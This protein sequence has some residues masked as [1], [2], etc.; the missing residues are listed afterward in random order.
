MVKS[1]ERPEALSKP[2]VGALCRSD[3]LGQKV[4]CFTCLYR[5]AV[6]SEPPSFL[7]FDGPTPR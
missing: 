6:Q 7:A 1:E 3:L 2:D 4:T 5:L